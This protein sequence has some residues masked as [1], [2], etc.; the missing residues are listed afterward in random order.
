MNKIKA[1]LEKIK[2]L[3]INN[4][5]KIARIALMLLIFISISVVSTL[6]LYLFGIIY[7]EDGIQINKELFS[8]FSTTWYGC[9]V[10]ILAQVIITS[11]LSFV[12]GA[13]M[14]FIILLETLYE[15]SW[16]AF[17]VAFSGVMLSSLMMY[18]IGRYGGY[19]LG[20]KLIGEEDCEK[21][22]D[23]LNN[24][25]LIYFPMMMMFPVFPDDALVMV[26]GTLK[27]SLKW[28]V[29]SIVFGRGIGVATIVFG[30]SIVPFEKFTSIWH[31]VAFILICAL[32]IIGIFFLANRFNKYME[33]K[34]KKSADDSATDKTEITK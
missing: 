22:S 28:F 18:L 25:G 20:K 26:A 17:I 23:L 10:I 31:W 1:G 14:A 32:L 11:L 33:K 9:I 8:Y 24:K 13:S 21:A 3:F 12:P 27:M 15:D 34:S 30:L 19:N 7:F 4:R 16:V 5:T 6:L 29:P 2:S